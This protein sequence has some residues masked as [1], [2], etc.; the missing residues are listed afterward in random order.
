MPFEVTDQALTRLPAGPLDLD[1]KP[2]TPGCAGQQIRR[3]GVAKFG[4]KVHDRKTCRDQHCLDRLHQRIS[5]AVEQPVPD[6]LRCGLRLLQRRLELAA[7]PRVPLLQFGERGACARLALRLQAG[8][9][10]MW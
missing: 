9:V 8:I 2:P 10:E 5:A 3:L 1:Q 7:L 6:R 4:V